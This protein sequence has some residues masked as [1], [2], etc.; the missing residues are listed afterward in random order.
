MAA[1]VAILLLQTCPHQAAAG[2]GPEARNG[3]ADAAYQTRSADPTEGYLRAEPVCDPIVIY[4]EPRG[5][6]LA[7]EI[8]RI[9]CAAAPLIAA[10][11]GLERTVIV[12]IAIARDTD[13]FR[14]LHGGRLPEWGEAFADMERALIGIDAARVLASPRPLRTVVLHELSHVLFEQRVSGA[15]AP[16]WL[17]EGLAMRQSGEWTLEDEWNLARSFWSEKMPRLEELEGQFP[18]PTGKAEAAYRISHAAVDFL[19]SDRPGSVVT[20]TAFLRDTGDFDRAFL[21]TYGETSGEFAERFHIRLEDRYRTAGAV[22]NASPYWLSLAVLF[23][24]VYAIKRYRTAKKVAEWERAEEDGG[25]AG[26][27]P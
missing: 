24:L 1:P 6:R 2:S 3:K 10:E 13:A 11:L 14:R 26:P 27:I 9:A 22:L 18:R 17:I 25:R 20:L 16:T 12:T 8:G 4:H 7:A 15:A 23:L 5:E 21:L 19:L